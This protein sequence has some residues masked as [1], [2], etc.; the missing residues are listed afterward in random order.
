M[1]DICNDELCT[2]MWVNGIRKKSSFYSRTNTYCQ[3]QDQETGASLVEID[4]PNFFSL[5]FGVLRDQ[6]Q[7][8]EDYST[9]NN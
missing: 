4:E 7:G 1:E 6:N 2:M 9:A 3:H 8:L 5:V